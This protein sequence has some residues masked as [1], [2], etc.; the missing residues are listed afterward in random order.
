MYLLPLLPTRLRVRF[1][2]LRQDVRDL[3]AWARP[4]PRPVVRSL[5]TP[6]EIQ[7]FSRQAA[8]AQ[9]ARREATRASGRDTQAEARLRELT[10]REVHHPTRDSVTLVFSN[11]ATDPITFTPGQ[12]LTLLVNIDGQELRRAYSFCSAPGDGSTVSI[13][14]KQVA[15]GRVSTW[16]VRHATP[17]MT[18]RAVGPSGR[19]GTSADRSRAREIVL[20]AGGSGITPLYAMLQALLAGEP[21][22]RVTLVYANRRQP[23]IIFRKELAALAKDHPWFTLRHVLETPPRGFTGPTGMLTGAVLEEALPV[24]TTAEYYVCGPDP[25][26]QGVQSFLQGAGVPASRIMMERFTGPAAEPTRS[27]LGL[28][29]SVNFTQSG[30]LLQVKDDKTLLEAGLAA[31][32]PMAFSCTFGGCGACKVQVLSGD[33]AMDEPNCLTEAERQRGEV[34]ACVC[35]PRGPVTLRA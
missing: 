18:L 25:M 29:H 31:G 34:L 8:L 12:F 23:D 30:A 4:T 35:R 9:Q 27:P 16:L 7:E 3:Q 1:S 15:G 5:H 11:P 13:T 21:R 17:G 32:I 10:V 22:T 28:T 19:F 14:V 26:M 6:A 24:S 33:V 2:E 20:V